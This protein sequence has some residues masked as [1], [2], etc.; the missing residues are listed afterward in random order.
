VPELEEY[1]A[2]LFLGLALLVGWRVSRKSTQYLAKF[3]DGARP[4][5]IQEEGTL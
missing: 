1:A 2:I 3:P 4:A 5:T